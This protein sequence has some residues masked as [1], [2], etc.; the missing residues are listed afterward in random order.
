MSADK[1]YLGD[2]LYADW[3][4]Q[5][6]IVTAENG[7]EATDTIYLETETWAALVDYIDGLRA[8]A[9]AAQEGKGHV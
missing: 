1:R 8:K 9:G 5:R 6:L 2:G 4:G 3:D 7:I